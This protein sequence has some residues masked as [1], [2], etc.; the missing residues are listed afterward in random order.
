M[1]GTDVFLTSALRN[2]RLRNHISEF[3]P[4]LHEA[5]ESKDMAAFPFLDTLRDTFVRPPELQVAALC[6]RE[7]EGVG[8]VLLLSSLNSGRWILP[9]GWPMNGRH[10]SEAALIEAWEEAGVRGRVDP[11]PIGSYT[12]QKIKGGGMPLRCQVQV[13]PVH[14]VTLATDFPE[15]G[16]RRRRW[17]SLRQAAGMVDEREL[18]ELLTRLA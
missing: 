10:L 3:W 1:T 16:R 8:Q 18:R 7:H 11:E 2:L 9:K 12:Y 13:F 4:K 17:V 6:R 15:A 5:A 14:D